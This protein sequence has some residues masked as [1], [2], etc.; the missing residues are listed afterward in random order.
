MTAAAGWILDGVLV[1]LLVG[2]AARLLMTR[3]LFEA[4]VMFVA[5]GLV[6]ALVWMR[7]GAAD[8]ALAEAALGAGVTGALFLNAW[9]RLSDR[10]R[11]APA[12][13]TEGRG[14]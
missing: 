3:D 2:L 12:G 10:A 7:V 5:Y 4:I 8:L 1:V 13:T 6:L 11:G 9:R 14:S